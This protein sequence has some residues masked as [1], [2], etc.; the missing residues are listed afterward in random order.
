MKIEKFPAN[1]NHYGVFIFDDI[2]DQYIKYVSFDSEAQLKVWIMRNAM[3]EYRAVL[4]NPLIDNITVKL[5]PIVKEKTNE[6]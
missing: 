2:D 5:L 1:K 3:L 6:A 4:V